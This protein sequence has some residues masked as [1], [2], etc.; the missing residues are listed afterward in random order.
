MLGAEQHGHIEKV[1]YEMYIELLGEAVE[2]ARTGKKAQERH[3]V[4][5]KVDAAAYIRDGYVSGRDKLRI[6]KRIAE[7]RSEAERRKLTEELTEVY[8]VPDAALKT[9]IA[10]A[11]LKN[12][13]A[14]FGASRVIVNRGG[15]GVHFADSS[16]FSD[17][18]L[19]AAVAEHRDEV[20]LTTAIPP[21]LIF[22]VKGLSVPE[23]L[24]KLIAFFS[25]AASLGEKADDAI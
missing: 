5:M 19:M 22:D 14:G 25:S 16:V 11:L 10:V 7:V 6:L 17:E 12:L 23:R 9:L 24:E 18:T 8:G 3:N 20:V 21:T 4:E 13:A 2:E 1:G 15:A